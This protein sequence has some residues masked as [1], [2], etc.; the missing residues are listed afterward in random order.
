MD[1]LN[2]ESNGKKVINTAVSRARK[3]L[4]IVCDYNYW[5][6]QESQ[7][8]GKLLKVA[9]RYSLDAYIRY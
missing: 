7:L 5:I 8:I 4:F 3:N 1:S 2:P 9:E 6:R